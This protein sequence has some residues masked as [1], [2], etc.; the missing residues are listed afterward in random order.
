MLRTWAGFSRKQQQVVGAFCLCYG[1]WLGFSTLLDGD[2]RCV[3]VPLPAPDP[4]ELLFYIEP[5]V[6]INTASCEELQLLPSIGPV[7]AERI[8]L[9][10]EQYGPFS[11]VDSV[12]AVR[13]IGPE[14]V[15]K[16][17]Y[18]LDN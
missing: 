7:L 3:S 6:D 16:L 17:R 4:P 5:S 9:Y 14:T 1:I 15:R 12:Q 11:S 10:R 2:Q 13:G 18:Y 8:I